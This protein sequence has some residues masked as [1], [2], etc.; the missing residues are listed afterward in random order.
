[1]VQDSSFYRV[2]RVS[3]SS[4][5]Q[6]PSRQGYSFLYSKRSMN[7]PSTP[8]K[9]YVYN[10]HY[11]SAGPTWRGCL[12]LAWACLAWLVQFQNLNNICLYSFW[13]QLQ[14]ICKISFRTR[15]VAC[16]P[17]SKISIKYASRDRFG[18]F[19]A[20]LKHP[21]KIYLQ[22]SIQNPGKI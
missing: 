3:I 8:P 14:S 2:P 6:S 19:W 12:W 21:G 20:Q 1:M 11:G 10:I 9:K 4:V 7:V 22:N 5:T 15:F 16:G 18:F 17:S 13:A